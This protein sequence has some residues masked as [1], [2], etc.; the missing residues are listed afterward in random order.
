MSDLQQVGDAEREK[1]DAADH[2][3]E[4]LLI[5]LTLGPKGDHTRHDRPQ[6]GLEG[7]ER[8]IPVHGKWEVEGEKCEPSG[9]SSISATKRENQMSFNTSPQKLPIP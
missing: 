5:V 4:A 2:D 1:R 3:R 9:V 8:L 7:V 6:D